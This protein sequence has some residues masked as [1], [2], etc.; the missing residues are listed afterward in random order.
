M[1][2]KDEKND[3]FGAVGLGRTFRLVSGGKHKNIEAFLDFYRSILSELVHH[4]LGQ[5]LLCTTSHTF[6]S[7]FGQFTKHEK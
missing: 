4:R 1:P 3:R 2:G 6:F 7:H 5:E